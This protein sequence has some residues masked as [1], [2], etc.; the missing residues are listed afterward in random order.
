M[1]VDATRAAFVHFMLAR[2]KQGRTTGYI[3]T[4]L[5]TCCIGRKCQKSV[6]FQENIQFLCLYFGG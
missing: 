6:P 3:Q 1:I 5:M 4:E 2:W